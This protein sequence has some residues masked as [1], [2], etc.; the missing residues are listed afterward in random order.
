M[1][2][3]MRKMAHL[4][5]PKS[6]RT[7]LRIRRH[8][9]RRASKAPQMLWGY[10]DSSGNWRERT[11]ISD[12]VFFYHPERITI[13]DNVFISHY[14]ILDGTGSIEIEEGVQ[15]GAWVGI[16]T[17]SSHIAIRLYGNHYS[18]VD[19]SVKKGYQVGKIRIGRYTFIGS[20]AKLLPGVSIGKGALISAGAV[21]NKSVEDFQLVAGYPPRVIGDTRKLDAMYLKDPELRAWYHEWQ[22]S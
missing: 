9:R 7:S 13:A 3:Y 21:V 12:T 18:E 1:F 15:M 6:I 11:R 5:V 19:E 8:A 20:G 4:L 17:H 22:K 16:F 14:A 10:L 2:G